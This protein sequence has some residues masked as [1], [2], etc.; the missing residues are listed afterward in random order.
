MKA[1]NKYFG[2]GGD[3][4]EVTKFGNCDLFSQKT[5]LALHK[6]HYDQGG[7]GK[8]YIYPLQEDTMGHVCNYITQGDKIMVVDTWNNINFHIK[9]IATFLPQ[10]CQNKPLFA[11]NFEEIKPCGLEV[12]SSLSHVTS[13]KK[14]LSIISDH[15]HKTKKKLVPKK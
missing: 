6:L 9:D 4:Y 11:L 5:S 13:L 15:Y 14:T 10:Y 3:G 2:V 12:I 1:Y 8:I 7:Y